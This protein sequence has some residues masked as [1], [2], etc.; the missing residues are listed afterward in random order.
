MN[1]DVLQGKWKQITGDLKKSFGKLT[2]D[3]LLQIEGNSDK[4]LG[5]LQE[6]YGY[7]REQ[8]QTEWSKFTGQHS[9]VFGDMKAGMGNAAGD[10]KNAANKTANDIKNAVK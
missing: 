9:D 7:T 5:K 2:D 3:D 4:M 8:A 10:V 6:R 1:T